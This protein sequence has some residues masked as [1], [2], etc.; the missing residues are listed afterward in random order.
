MLEKAQ[1]AL[2]KPSGQRS[3]RRL[4]EA[5]QERLLGWMV[6]FNIKRRKT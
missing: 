1:P 2:K 6:D 5:F 4:L 3:P